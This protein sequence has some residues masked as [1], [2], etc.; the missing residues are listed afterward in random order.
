[1]INTNY[2]P[3]KKDLATMIEKKAEEEGYIYLDDCNGTDTTASDKATGYSVFSAS[4]A[5]RDFDEESL[6]RFLKI[7]EEPAIEICN[8]NGLVCEVSGI[9]SARKMGS[10]NMELYSPEERKRH[11][12]ELIETNGGTFR[13]DDEFIDKNRRFKVTGFAPSRPKY[14]ILLT[15]VGD[16]KKHKASISHTNETVAGGSH[17]QI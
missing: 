4:I 6:S 17:A 3:T 5:G 15:N 2:Y 14:P 13:V 1:M 11:S 12:N 10:I 9:Y 7:I 16:G 8:L